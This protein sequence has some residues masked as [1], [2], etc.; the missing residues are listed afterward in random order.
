MFVRGAEDSDDLLLR[1]RVDDDIG[2]HVI[3]LRLEDG[4]IPV[5]V[6]AFLLDDARVVLDRDVAE[7]RAEG[8]HVHL[9]S[10]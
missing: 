6:A 7:L 3:E 8:C 5:V 4:R 2:R 1:A 9:S 10:P